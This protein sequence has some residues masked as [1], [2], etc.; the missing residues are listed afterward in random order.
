MDLG[1]GELSLIR[2]WQFFTHSETRKKERFRL[3]LGGV[4]GGHGS[5]GVKEQGG[6]NSFLSPGEVSSSDS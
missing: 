5:P 6:S 2:T 1:L 3:L 4:V